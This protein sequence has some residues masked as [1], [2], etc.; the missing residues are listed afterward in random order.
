MNEL[1]GEAGRLLA[2]L[3]SGYLPYLIPPVI[4]FTE[5]D[6]ARLPPMTDGARRARLD[7][8]GPR[9]RRRQVAGPDAAR[10]R[11]LPDLGHRLERSQIE[12]LARI[13]AAV[14]SVKRDDGTIDRRPRRRHHRRRRGRRARRAR[15]PVP[16]RRLPDRVGHEQQHEHER[17]AGHA[18][19]GGR[20]AGRSIRTTTSTTRCRRTTCSPPRSTS[21]PSRASCATWS[22]RSSTWPA[23]SRRKATEFADVVKSGRT[24]LM[25]ATPVTLGQEFGGYAAQVRHRGRAAPR[26]AAAR[27]GAAAR[28]HRGRHRHQ[29][30]AGLRRA[31]HRRGRRGHRPAADRGARPLRGPGRARR[32]GRALRPAAHDRGEPDQDRQRPALDGVRTARRPGRDQPARPPAGEQHHAGQGEP[33]HPRG[34]AHGLRAGRR[35]RRRRRLGRRGRQLRAQRHAAGASA[36]T[37]SSRSGSWPTSAGSSPTDASTASPPTSSGCASTRS[38]RR[39]S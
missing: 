39:R 18:G 7:G 12:A 11:E 23:R 4:R 20:S 30:A 22:R 29:R 8:R 33:G 19:R 6:D 13:K 26:N 3:E 28:R 37:C 25:D 10:G 21:P 15:R 31:R 38:R 36:A 2:D 1:I 24:H 16:D 32:A 17:G 27:R 14:A 34:H 35:Q 5:A 9:A